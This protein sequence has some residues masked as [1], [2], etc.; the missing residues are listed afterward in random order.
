MKNYWLLAILIAGT[1]VYSATV[2]S[3]SQNRYE[4][5]ETSQGLFLLNKE[6]G[7]VYK[8]G[9]ITMESGEVWEEGWFENSVNSEFATA[10]SFRLLK[11]RE[12][13]Q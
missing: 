2:I 6:Y 9:K 4:I 7:W 13:S 3:T 1:I 10:E 12:A 5:Y 8:Y 11:E